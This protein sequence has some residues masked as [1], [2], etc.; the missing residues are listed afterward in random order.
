MERMQ[1]MLGQEYETFLETFGQERYQALRLNPLKAGMYGRSAAEALM[2]GKAEPEYTG[3]EDALCGRDFARLTGVSW[4]ENGYYY[5]S[6]DQPGKHPYHDAGLYYIQEPSA[7]VP[8]E[9]LEAKPGERI[10]DLCAAP[11]GKST[12]IAAKL[13]G[14]GLLVSNE[15]NSARAKILSE[16]IERMGIVNACV[17]NETPEKLADFFPE[18]FDRILVDAPCS[19]EGM[20][21]KNE[22]ACEEWSPEN[23]AMCARRQDGILD[24][25]AR[26]L[27]PGGRLVYS[28]CTF[29]P[30]ENE[31]SVARFL[32]CHGDFAILPI[33]KE[34]LGITGC[35]G[36]AKWVSEDL[37]D[38]ETIRDLGLEGTLRLWPHKVKGEGHFAAVLRKAGEEPEKNFGRRAGKCGEGL[39]EKELRKSGILEELDRFCRENLCF[40]ANEGS[41]LSVGLGRAA[42]L[43]EEAVWLRFGDHLYLAPGEMPSLR[44]LRVLRPGLQIGEMKKNRFEP[45]HALA[46]AL[47]PQNALHKWDLPSGGREVLNYLQGN[48]FPVEGEKGWYLICV[49]G[50]GIGWGKL[51]SGIMKNHYPRGLRKS[52]S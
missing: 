3:Q 11:G 13:Q 36:E 27:R 45:S 49:D 10:L 2:S 44:S 38:Y 28:T 8:A 37:A 21:R 26:M 19:G 33:E 7:M 46:L 14:R 43:G 32:Q 40:P 20:F 15:I 47:P 4:A 23:V 17:T 51:A 5:R 1:Q 6:E 9:L 41:P 48:T 31:G 50:F 30:E 18:Y 42:G 39:S 24:C 22:A 25:A 29:A 34:S 35:D 16:N 52:G 12:Q